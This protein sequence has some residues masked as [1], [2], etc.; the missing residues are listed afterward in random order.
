MEI[1]PEELDWERLKQDFTYGLFGGIYPEDTSNLDKLAEGT[2]WVNANEQQSFRWRFWYPEG[3]DRSANLRLF[4]LLDERQLNDA[5]PNSGIYNDI[6]LDRGDDIS[7]KVIIPPLDPGIHDIIA[8]GVPYL[9]EY[10]NEYGIVNL[11]YWRITL[12]AEPLNSPFRK[13]NF[14]SLPAEGSIKNHDPWMALELTLKNDGI[15]VWNWPD[16]WLTVNA[17]ASTRFYALAG[18]ED[19]TNLD[20]PPMDE[21]EKSFF[22]L[23]LFVDYQQ[24]EIAPGQMALYGRVDKDTA[25]A[26]IPLELPPLAEGKH[27]LLVLGID[28]PGVPVCILKGDPKGRIL[29]NSIYGKLVGINVVPAE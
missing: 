6:N 17:N 9:E 28:T 8:I 26:R 21:L 15:D 7:L 29:P 20:A 3:N 16:P 14:V 23:L 12:I 2:L 22:S 19:V 24:V 13:S 10:P 5:L 4:V 1:S 18:H 25:Y 27:H 11:V